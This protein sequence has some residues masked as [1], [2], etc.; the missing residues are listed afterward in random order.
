[1]TN[2]EL[3]QFLD[4]VSKGKEPIA[5]LAGETIDSCNLANMSFPYSVDFSHVTFK[6]PA[7]FKNVGFRGGATFVGTQFR[8]I[9]DFGWCKFAGFGYF[10]NCLF[11]KTASFFQSVFE[12]GSN[13]AESSRHPGEAN[14]SYTRFQKDVTFHRVRFSGMCYFHRTSFERHA[15]FSECRFDHEVRFEGW[16]NDVCIQTKEIPAEC[17][18][19]LHQ[20]SLVCVCAD[21]PGDYINFD[22]RIENSDW[23]RKALENPGTTRR[24]IEEP[25][26]LAKFYAKQF[27]RRKGASHPP[28]P[29][30]VEANHHLQSTSAGATPVLAATT[31]ST[32]RPGVDSQALGEQSQI[33]VPTAPTGAA[34]LNPDNIRQTIALYEER[35]RLPM[36]SPEF[37]VSFGRVV[38]IGGEKGDERTVFSGVDLSMCRFEGCDISKC[39]FGEDVV[40]DT[41]VTALRLSPRRA[42]HDEDTSY[43]VAR[44][45]DEDGKI[46][47]DDKAYE[48]TSRTLSCVDY[49]K[50]GQL[51]RGLRRMAEERGELELA[52][53]FYFGEMEMAYRARKLPLLL[54]LYRY[55]SGFGRQHGLA[56]TWLV[57]LIFAIF[58]MLYFGVGRYMHHATED[59]WH[60]FLAAEARSLEASTLLAPSKNGLGLGGDLITGLER[61]AVPLQAGLLLLSVRYNFQRN[62]G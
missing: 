16:Q 22:L 7:I 2:V 32:A 55:A 11:G 18:R 49:G 31:I 58:P 59:R 33:P 40:W 51:Y 29:P 30:V 17:L 34:P 8:D 35:H 41:R 45:I 46:R 3:I 12:A 15:D 61:I 1:M 19:Y 37:E 6:G 52:Q 21:R 26:W 13:H 60:T 9:A 56:A 53:D 20:Q 28:T 14:F 54:F 38:Q 50:V 4:R 43:S 44:F 25:G 42:L 36:F 47:V 48:E 62:I 23:L 57:L 24:L 27:R 5:S 39:F 10:W